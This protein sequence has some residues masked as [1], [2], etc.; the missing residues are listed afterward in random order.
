MAEQTSHNFAPDPP[1]YKHL[2]PKT[3]G[4]LRQVN[5]H[6]QEEDEAAAAAVPATEKTSNNNNDMAASEQT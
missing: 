6:Q 4:I 3:A 5:R 1:I 2:N